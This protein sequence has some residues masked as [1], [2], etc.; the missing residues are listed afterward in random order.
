MRCIRGII[1][2]ATIGLA[3]C[4]PMQWVKPGAD[5]LRLGEDTAKCQ[6]QARQEAWLGG[7]G[8]QPMM[9]MVVGDA[10]GRRFVFWQRDYFDPFGDRFMEEHRLTNACLRAN[11]YELVPVPKAK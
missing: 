2:S 1:L 9:P 4:T 5:A 6:Q 7:W 3:A 10:R 8:F 11:G